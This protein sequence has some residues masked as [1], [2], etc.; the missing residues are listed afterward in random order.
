MSIERNQA[1]ARIFLVDDHALMRQQL[2]ALIEAESDLA[3][4]GEAEAAQPALALIRQQAPDL[5][6]L[7]LSLKRSSGLDLLA[8]LGTLQPRP[9][10][11]VLSMH[12][13]SL[14]VER[15]FRAGA[16]GYITKQDATAN[17]LP[18]IRQVLRGERYLSR[19]LLDPTPKRLRAAREGTKALQPSTRSL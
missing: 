19:Q 9:V 16:L 14:Y 3:V 12:E 1:R 6:L 4:C 18:A 17:I 7:D 8:D 2:T 15:S 10:V 13:E 11:L 5:V